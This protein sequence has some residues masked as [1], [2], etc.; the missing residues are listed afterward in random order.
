[1]TGI[2]FNE[3]EME[4]ICVIRKVIERSCTQKEAGIELGLSDR[5]V[6]RVL[7]R[8]K[9][10]GIEGI[11]KKHTGG[12]RSFSEDF[13]VQVMGLVREH[14]NDFG[15][16]FASQKLSLQHGLEINRETL[17]QWMMIGG[18]WKGRTRKKARIHQQ[19]ERRSCFG[20]LVQ[21][22]GS[23]HDWFEGRASKCCLLVFIP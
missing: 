10:C 9:A 2:L 4:R 13:K 11:Q 15:P 12:N 8:F 20:E 18:I 1:M 23:H 7:E 3:D 5:Q 6:R 14:Y 17:R 22:D 19:R 16:R 21:I